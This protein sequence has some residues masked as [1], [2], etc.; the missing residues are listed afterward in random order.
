MPDLKIGD[1]APDFATVN[2]N[3]DAVSLKGLRGKRVVLYFYPK[4]NTSGCTAQA[5]AFRDA[6]PQIEDKNAVVLGVSPDSA[7]SHQSFKNKFE[8][9]FPLLIDGDHKIADAY[10]VWREKSMYG[11]KYMGI[12]RS[13]FVIDE[14]GKLADVQYNVKAT[15]SAPKALASLG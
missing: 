9:P 12:L 10:G 5:C 13:H 8:L 4:D 3:G 7:K 14:Q 6:Y 1:A 2:E 11:R 15:D